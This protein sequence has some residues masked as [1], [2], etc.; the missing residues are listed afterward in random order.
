MKPTTPP[1]VL[2]RPYFLGGVG[3]GWINAL[4]SKE[5]ESGKKSERG[6]FGSSSQTRQVF[7]GHGFLGYVFFLG[8]EGE[9]GILLRSKENCFFSGGYC[10]NFAYVVQNSYGI[11]SFLF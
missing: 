2:L 3:I 7:R 1:K 4:N 5:N 6:V 11:F 9:K 10:K 8:W